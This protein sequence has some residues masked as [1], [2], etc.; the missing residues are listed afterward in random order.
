MFTILVADDNQLIVT[1][2]ERIMQKSKLVDDLCFLVRPT[3][4]GYNMENCTVTMLYC[5]PES[6][7]AVSET[8]TKSDEMHGEFLQYILPFDTALTSEAGDVKVKL[9]FVLADLDAN[10]KPIQR[11]RKTDEVVIPI[12]STD[13]WSSI[14][15]DS[16]LDAIDQRIIKQD[17]QI[18][19]LEEI[20]RMYYDA[21]ADGLRY[22]N[23]NKEL[24]LLSGGKAIGNKVVIV[25]T[26]DG[27][28]DGDDCPVVEF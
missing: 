18:K 22:N 3:Y 6:R 12:V 27:D 14:I 19:E 17:A 5:L 16:A 1:K 20:S 9:S 11:V 21:K 10:G 26:S 2:K 28:S 25:S 7:K 24:Q 23:G 8:L 13:A 4:K 15:P